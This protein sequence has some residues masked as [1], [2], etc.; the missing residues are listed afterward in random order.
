MLDIASTPVNAPNRTHALR[1]NHPF[2]DCSAVEAKTFSSLGLG[3]ALRALCVLTYASPAHTVRAMVLALKR[4]AGLPILI[5]V[6]LSIASA[7]RAQRPELVV[8]TGHTGWVQS[9]AFS[10]DG[11]ILASGS[12][13]NTIRLWNSISGRELRSLTGHS[14]PVT[15]VAFSPDGR[16]LASGSLDSTVKIW[17]LGTCSLL[18]T[19]TDHTSMV[20]AVAF[21]PDGRTL[22]SGSNDKTIKLWNVETGSEVRTLS[23]HTRALSSLAF[24]ADGKF[25]AS[26][27]VDGTIKLWDSS[28]GRAVQTFEAQSSDV[29]AIALSPDGKTLAAGSEDRTIRLWNLASGSQF[30][31]LPNHSNRVSSV[32]FSPDG[33]IL[34]SGSSS[35]VIL[36]DAAS[37]GELGSLAGH[38]D[39]VTSIAFNP[40]G[41][42][43]ASGSD[44]NTIKLWDVSSGRV[45]RSLTGHARGVTA[46]ASSPDGH[47]LAFGGDDNTI[48]LADLT[49]GREFRVLAG[50]ADKIDALAFSPDSRTLA[51]AGHDSTIELWDVATRRELRVMAGHT[52]WISSVAFS[53]DGRTIASGS[54]DNTVRLWD[55]A[56]GHEVWTLTGHSAA[57]YAVLFSSDGQK[58]ISGSYDG[59]IKL[60]NVA[61]GRELQTLARPNEIDNSLALSPDGNTLAAGADDHTIKF[62]D[63]KSGRELPGLP[64]HSNSI[65]ALAF[66][67][68]GKTLASGSIDLTIKLWDVANRRELKTLTGH[69]GMV[70]ALAFGGED[71]TIASG[72]MDGTVRLWDV[73]SGRQLASLIALNQ[74]NWAVVDSA[75]RFDASPGG[76]KLMHWAVGLEPIDLAQ[77]K[78]RYYEPGLLPKVLGYN[79]EPLRDVAAF[80][81]VKLF[82]EATARTPAPSSTNLV[83]DL[84]N[85][86]GGIGR[87]QVFVN[88]KELTA[89]A[90]G[91]KLNPTASETSLTV[92]LAGAPFKRGE[93]NDIRV[94]TWNQE[95][96]LSSRGV[97]VTWNP[98]GERD[99][100]P[101]DMYAIVA[102]ISDYSSPELNL[103]FA[104]KDAADMARAIDLGARR[105]LGAEHVHL[106]LLTSPADKGSALATKENIR[107]AFEAARKAKPSDILVVYLAGHGVA[108]HDIYA[109]PAEDAR[110][111][112]LADPA[113]RAQTA[114]SSE[115]FAEWMKLVPA[116]HQ[117]M[118]IDTCAAGAA[119]EKLVEK[120]EVPGDQVRAIERLKD[121]MGVFVLMGSAADAASYEASQFGQGLLTYALLRGMKGAALRDDQY[122]DVA[123]L[124]HD[125]EDEV[126]ELARN[127]GGVQQPRIASP[128]GASF[129]IGK[130]LLEDRTEIPLATVRPLLLRPEFLNARLHRDNLGLSSALRNR[131]RDESYASVRGNSGPMTAVF[132]DQDD[133][134]GGVSP[135]GDYTVEGTQIK[136]TVVLAREDKE[137]A[138]VSV[139][140]AT[141]DLNALA[142][143]I[144][145]E[146]DRV[147]AAQPSSAQ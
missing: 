117:V 13:D 100:T 37:G 21:S 25:L 18:R 38:T 145:A 10:P 19:L 119:A 48:K 112:D 72:S 80:N 35:E 113:V 5:F 26:G 133:F 90:R 81:D 20:Y 59:T 138:Q 121:R 29:Y 85:R 140:G 108:I 75:G 70:Y 98:G 127:I 33:R 23:G 79:K 111:L 32:A 43:L 136:V 50:H 84:K 30:L 141:D 146:I 110:T 58:V 11:R 122:V 49:G 31:S 87:V 101:P 66:S 64:G 73:A 57:V 123:R 142:A 88:G 14:E 17:D 78:E 130:L 36:W 109:Y 1:V 39:L 52:S 27:S 9:V 139:E 68:D 2:P 47:I 137:I 93:P 96:Y 124:F 144:A 3:S 24:S 28:T 143:R 61:G 83:V 105:L 7:A 116:L 77:L 8:E 114:I 67:P 71:R 12:H 94:V 107:K 131:L 115:E 41:R 44:D 104:S 54:D 135:S 99:L 76:M 74:D 91:P 15:S 125:A 97:E 62:W 89:D 51:S 40:D 60:W 128:G 103:H 4:L 22:A 6:A 16:F 134:P 129:D 120:R 86:G 147:L 69:S 95:G 106:T 82:P 42:T 126:P 34:A 118:I 92:N 63:L 46:V 45:V 56:T 55:V 65:Y 53:P 102:G 132:V